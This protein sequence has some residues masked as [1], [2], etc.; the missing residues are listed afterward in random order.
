MAEIITKKDFIGIGTLVQV[1]GLVL[2]VV[3]FSFGTSGSIVGFIA[4]LACFVI[5]SKM[6][7]KYYCGACMNRVEST[8]VTVCPACRSELTEP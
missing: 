5:G 4:F 7:K 6:S 2:M 1:A 3:S 8:S